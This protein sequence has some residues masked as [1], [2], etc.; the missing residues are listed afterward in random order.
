M[1]KPGDWEVQAVRAVSATALAAARGERRMR[2]R[3]MHTSALF[4]ECH[5]VI[6]LHQ[7]NGSLKARASDLANMWAFVFATSIMSIYTSK[8]HNT[9]E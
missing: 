2:R 9:H 5:T 7:R 4:Y 1:C 8:T 3:T 6:A